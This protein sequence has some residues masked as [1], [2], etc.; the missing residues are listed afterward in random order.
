M[1]SDRTGWRKSASPAES[2]RR[3]QK[4]ERVHAGL[5]AREDL[6]D[7][8]LAQEEERLRAD[9]ERRIAA[10]RVTVCAP[11]ATAAEASYAA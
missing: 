9:I 6:S 8:T 3:R 7:E 4:K 11:G 2:L 1:S 5:R 10:G